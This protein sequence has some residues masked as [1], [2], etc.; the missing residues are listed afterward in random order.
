MVLMDA[1]ASIAA[2]ENMR[3]GH[4]G[5]NSISMRMMMRCGIFHFPMMTNLTYPSCPTMTSA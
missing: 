1:V 3:K 2:E 5:I 4:A